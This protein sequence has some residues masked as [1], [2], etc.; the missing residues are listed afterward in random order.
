MISALLIPL[1]LAAPGWAQAVPELPAPPLPAAPAAPPDPPAAPPE[2]PAAAPDAPAAAPDAPAAPPAPTAPAQVLRTD[3]DPRTG[4]AGSLGLPPE[5]WLQV[6]LGEGAPPMLVEAVE[7]KG[8]RRVEEAAIQAAVRLTTGSELTM[9]AVRADLRA[10]FATGFVDDVRVSVSPGREAGRYV[11]TFTVD[12]KPAVREVRLEGNKKLDEDALREV[13]DIEINTVYNEAEVARNIQRMRE[14]YVEKGYYLA[15]IEPLV[16]EVGD[17][18]VELTLKVTE[19]RK[20][21][22]QRV[23]ITGNEG[24]PDRKIKRFIQ[25][26]EA[27]I[28]FL[29]KSGSFDELKLNDDVQIIRSVFMEEGYIEASVDSPQVYLSPDK[30]FIYVTINVKEGKKYKLG[31]LKVRGDMVPAEGLTEEAVRRIIEGDTAKVVNERWAKAKAANEAAG[32]PDAPLAEGWEQPGKSPLRFDPSHPEMET[33]DTF[34]LSVMQQTLAEI[35]DLYGDQGYAFANVV[36]ITETDEESGVVDIIFEVQRGDKLRVDRI[37]ITGNDP[38]F[39]KV[40]RREIPINEGEI[41]SGSKVKEARQRLERLGYFEEVRISTPRS[42][43]P[44]SLDML[45]DVTEQPTGSFS[46]GAGFSNIENFMLTANVSKNNFIGMGYV[47]S[48]SAQISSQRQQ[49]NLQLFD[50]YFLDSRWTFSI[51]GYSNATQFIEDQYQRGGS[52]S[53]GRYL[54]QRNDT[55]LTFDYTFE[56]TGLR[57]LDSYKLRLLGGELYRNGLT[58]TGGL[59]FIVDK[60]NNRIQATRGVFATASTALSGGYRSDEDT[61]TQ[62]FGGDFNFVESKLNLRAYQPVVK[63]EWLIFKYNGTL[64]KIWSTDGT[65]VPFI[66]RYRA[67]G[68][69]SVRGFA[70]FSLGPSLRAPGFKQPQQ[71]SFLGS[72]DPTAPDD[73]LIVGGTETWINNFELESPIIKQAGISTVIFFDA[74]NAFGDV[75][76]DGNMSLGGLRGA[77][78]FGV[79]WFSPM[80]PLRFEW[81]VPVNPRP[82]E[83]R[84]VF[85]FSI[86]SLF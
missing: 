77:Y 8:L 72:E 32:T 11:L 21:Q 52:V 1:V 35:S 14:K 78:G 45:V 57:A 76:G 37:Q 58:S 66:H 60:R 46:V 22:L 31:K 82:D 26:K 4:G 80:G 49:W 54:D 59:S 7:V 44:E 17:D 13:I 30:R 85:D 74:G 84:I 5:L 83:R 64:G 62:V 53:I 51:N 10:V 25:T 38:T 34:K 73:R 24:V 12:E 23:D 28:P 36:P 27:A 70:W 42:K 63:K 29:T 3:E 6:P 16:R 15:E 55:R 20:V 86:G 61:I 68:I 48:A 2:A 56:D 33:G 19:N 47:M 75:W 43:E 40:I 39:D 69:Q 81:G 79:R 18:Q 65:I 71:Y 67:G 9:A 50:P 41:Y